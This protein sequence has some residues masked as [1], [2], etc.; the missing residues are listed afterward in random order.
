M[1][2]D[3]LINK[4]LHL[5]TVKRNL[6]YIFIALI[7]T[8]ACFSFF[9]VYSRN[10]VGAQENGRE[11]V[12]SE[13][14]VMEEQFISDEI[15][16]KYSESQ[17][18]S[19]RN[20]YDF[21][22]ARITSRGEQILVVE[23][24]QFEKVLNDL[25]ND[26]SV[27][28]VQP[29]YKYSIDVID[30]ND[31]YRNQLWGLDNTGQQ[32]LGVN[33]IA[34]ADIDA[35]EAWERTTGNQNV[36]VAVIDTGIAYNHP[37]LDG[38][39]WNGANCVDYNN[40]YMGGCIH[41]YDFTDFYD[42][43]PLSSGSDHGTHV[44]GTIAAEINNNQGIVGVAP[45]VKIMALKTDLYTDEIADAIQFAENNGAKIINASWGSSG[46]TC[47]E[48]YDSVLYNSIANFNG[49]FVT[50]AGNNS[51]DHDSNSFFGS[52]SDYGSNTGC[53]TELDNIVTVAASTSQDQI[54]S[55]SD[56]GTGFVDIAAPG[57]YIYSA[58][59]GQL[60]KG[61]EDFES[62]TPPALPGGWGAPI[63]DWGTIDLGGGWAN[64][65]FGDTSTYPYD[66][67]SDSYILLPSENLAE[68]D[69]ASLGFWTTCDTEYTD[70][71][72]PS[73]TPD[74]MEISLSSNG[75]ISYGD[76]FRWN[77]Y[78]IDDDLSSSGSESLFVEIPLPDNYI[79]SQF[80]MRLR[81]VTD[82]SDNNHEGCGVD[83]IEIV[84]F[85][86]SSSIGTYT[87]KNGTSMA[88]PHVS[89]AAGLVWSLDQGADYL[90]I[91]NLIL[92]NADTVAGLSGYTVGGKRLNVNAA[93]SQFDGF[94][95]ESWYNS[96]IG[97]WGVDS[98][99]FVSSGDFDNDGDEDV[100]AM[101]DYGRNKMG[102]WVMENDGA[103]GFD[104]N[105]WYNSGIGN[106]G[107][108]ATRYFDSGD[109]NNDG[110]DDAV[111]MY[112]YGNNKMGIWAF[113]SNGN[114][115]FTPEL[116]YNSG[117]GNWGVSATRFLTVG[118]YDN[119]G[120]DDVAAMYDYGNNKM[121]IWKFESSG[122]DLSAELWYNSGVGNWGVSATR[123]L[124]SADVDDDGDDDI[125]A[126]YD[127]GSNKMG[128]WLF[129]NTGPGLQT[130]LGYN[131]GI[132]NWG[133][134]AT[135]FMSTGD[136]DFSVDDNDDIYMMYDYGNNRI[137]LWVF[138]STGS[139]T[140]NPTIKYNS[141]EN[142]WG[143]NATKFMSVGD[144]NGVGGDDVVAMYDYGR[145]KMGLW[146][147]INSN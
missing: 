113:I 35:P 4:F 62:V 11:K 130:S 122:S 70:P 135:K 69:S 73:L 27:Q 63:G 12:S 24:D 56:H 100:I 116:W 82:S 49:L 44:A 146:V 102:I 79:T 142:N 65:L 32:I 138:M 77:E 99:K 143:A 58:S 83:D 50:S 23:E 67:N 41:G 96:G 22:V 53:W 34:D 123:F 85:Y 72:N 111:A 81:W 80:T 46:S 108:S 121:G 97:N 90:D 78:N 17:I 84:G 18:S 66:S 118:D 36:I 52:P 57:Q 21:E 9:T 139:G 125:I 2:I 1:S 131:S 75:G 106:W 59:I 94:I 114:G 43:D 145:N 110:Y 10:N 29:N 13:R 86:D 20:N 48:V 26:P 68:F 60:S 95:A 31:S 101:Y 7:F 42:K 15:I 140:F 119:D 16:V 54:A 39:L 3:L 76:T 133:V 115:G 64:T 8:I 127:Y 129:E 33:G 45:G 107:V 147:F 28:Y 19:L 105:L 91:K 124:N 132:G 71:F 120:Y 5:G 103:D 98:T 37:D 61:V 88:S 126:M 109:F 55:F 112:D 93:V 25:Q 104:P 87:Y 14:D 51:A 6:H 30:T 38:S 137:G 74:Y 40:T 47:G 92:D 128:L 89:G 136:F 134:S 144:F 117:V 141:G